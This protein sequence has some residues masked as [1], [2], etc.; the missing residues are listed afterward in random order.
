M[1]TLLFAIWNLSVILESLPISSSG[2]VR[3]F[4]DTITQA[5]GPQVKLLSSHTEH[6][7]HIPNGIMLGYVL[8]DF[9]LLLNE[10]KFTFHPLLFVFSVMISCFITGIVYLI[11]ESRGTPP[12]KLSAGFFI[13]GCGLISLYWAP[14]PTVTSVLPLHAIIIGC[15]QS[16]SLLPGISRMVS[17][18]ICSQWLG[19]DPT[20]GFAFSLACEFALICVALVKAAVTAPYLRI[21]KELS[22]AQVIILSCSTLL[23][24]YVLSFSYQGFVYRTI[25]LLGWYLIGLSVFLITILKSPSI[26][27]DA[28]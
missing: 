18:M 9:I 21:V 3:L 23:S 17:T 22:L 8:I 10:R 25:P 12:F 4:V 19:I 2:H 5:R 6:I 13:S 14:I 28:Q 11:F 24:Y 16:F 7:I 1:N 27:H 20:I 15:A 26:H